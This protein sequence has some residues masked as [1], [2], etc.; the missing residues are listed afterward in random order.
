[1]Q[2]ILKST[3]HYFGESVLSINLITSYMYRIIDLVNSLINQ[4]DKTIIV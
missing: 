2:I 1:M 3:L 4:I